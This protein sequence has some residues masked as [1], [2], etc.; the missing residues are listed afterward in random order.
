M[1]MMWLNRQP[2]DSTKSLSLSLLNA[3]DDGETDVGP[4]GYASK[5]QRHQQKEKNNPFFAAKLA[6]FING[7]CKTLLRAYIT[8]YTAELIHDHMTYPMSTNHGKM[9]SFP[10]EYVN[11]D[12]SLFKINEFNRTGNPDLSF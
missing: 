7:E 11:C 12:P 1:G 3:I 10:K 9:I 2:T 4:N 8:V 6:D 5:Q